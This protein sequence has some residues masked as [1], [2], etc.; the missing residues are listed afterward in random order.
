MTIEA[1][2][3]NSE[4]RRKSEGRTKSEIRMPISEANLWCDRRVIANDGRRPLGF[5]ISAFLRASSIGLRHS[6][7]FRISVF[8]FHYLGSC[9]AAGLL[10]VP[11]PLLASTNTALDEIP[12]LRPPR[13]EIPP[14]FWEQRGAWVI[15][16]S[17]FLLALV[18]VAVWFARRAKPRAE[19]PPEVLARQELE[20]LRAQAEN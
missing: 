3:P 5:R 18:S 15:P 16:S 19:V 2:I 10:L 11:L 14:G 20:P 1:R 4:I 13:G 17:L 7:G 9:L 6:F 8:G 12:P